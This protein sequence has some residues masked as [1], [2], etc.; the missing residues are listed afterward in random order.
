MFGKATQR[1]FEWVWVQYLVLLRVD[2]SPQERG[3]PTVHVLLGV[4]GQ[5]N[6]TQVLIHI[7]A[8][9]MAKHNQGG[10]KFYLISVNSLSRFP[11]MLLDENFVTFKCQFTSWFT[12]LKWQTCMEQD[13]HTQHIHFPDLDSV[14]KTPNTCLVD[15]KP[16]STSLSLR[17][18][19]GSMYFFSF[20]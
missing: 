19:R 2:P 9:W 15:M 14:L 10:C 5:L 12:E 8:W 7:P 18:S 20:S 13:T 6:L 4:T 16:F 11:S 17:L 3:F 1:L